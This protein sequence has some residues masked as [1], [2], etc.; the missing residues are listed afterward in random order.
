[1]KYIHCKYVLSYG[2]FYLFIS[3]CH[4]IY[5]FISI[6]MYNIVSYLALSVIMKFFNCIVSVC[7]FKY[8]FQSFITLFRLKLNC[9]FS[10]LY[11]SRQAPSPYS[12]NK[13]R[14]VEKTLIYFKFLMHSY[15]IY[16]IS[17][18]PPFS[19]LRYHSS[20]LPGSYTGVCP[21]RGGLNCFLS[22]GA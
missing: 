5:I 12:T 14:I 2:S 19:Y 4:S 16:Q 10:S 8:I 22:R 11:H 17:S 1:M 15:V 20:S 21:G 6:Y 13:S 9:F 3:F 18:L 7:V